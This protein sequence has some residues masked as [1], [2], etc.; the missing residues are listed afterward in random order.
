[1][2]R[3]LAC[4]RLIPKEICR[5]QSVG[6]WDTNPSPLNHTRSSEHHRNTVWWEL[7]RSVWW[8][9][10]FC[11]RCLS[12][13]RE[14]RESYYQICITLYHS[15]SMQISSHSA[16]LFR[17]FWFDITFKYLLGPWVQPGR[18][19]DFFEVF[20]NQPKFNVLIT[21]LRLEESVE[22]CHAV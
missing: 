15:V 6:T 3:L 20:T 18:I 12:V 2:F 8:A 9:L 22:C 14:K 5:C 1:M 19:P 10:S 4:L 11:G 7:E 17:S 16:Y 21:E 13:Y